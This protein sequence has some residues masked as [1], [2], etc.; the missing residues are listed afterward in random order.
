M[1][2]SFKSKSTYLQWFICLCYI[3][4]LFPTKVSN[5]PLILLLI[6][7]LVTF[8]GKQ[9]MAT[10]KSGLFL[11]FCIVYYLV[12]VI[13]LIYTEDLKSGLFILEK[14]IS[15]FLLPLLLFHHTS[16]FSKE[17]L[18]S[19]F[20]KLGIITLAGSA[21]VLFIAIFK[22]IVLHDEQAFFFEKFSPIHY[23]YY[24]IYFAI[25][26]LIFLDVTFGFFQKQ[27]YGLTLW[28]LLAAYAMGMLILISSKMGIVS[29]VL[30]ASV[31]IFIRTSNK[32]YFFAA[33][34]ILITSLSLFISVH[35]TTR[36][37]FLDLGKNF[38]ILH[39]DQFVYKENEEFT[40]FNLR[41]LFWKFS[42]SHLWETNSEIIGVG[43]GDAQNFIDE[44]YALHNLSVYDYKGWDPHNQWV[45]MTIQLGFVGASLLLLFYLNGFWIA[46]RHRDVLLFSFL[47]ITF[48]FSITESMLESNKGIVFFALFSV[49]LFSPYSKPDLKALK[50]DQ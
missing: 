36:Q 2:L 24:A 34:V 19:L 22:S 17:E 3:G 5:I 26:S 35:D 44:S 50:P 29:F 25:G 31:L 20:T 47:F 42:L 23:V 28:L 1:K 43:T 16:Q 32:K 45:F 38:E 10:L 21:V 48:C 33:V 40:G 11:K 9:F 37:R 13:G 39:V 41:V 14:K 46:I 12:Q 49:L 4:L 6:Y 15:L 30:G 8:N 7:S 18:K 27:K